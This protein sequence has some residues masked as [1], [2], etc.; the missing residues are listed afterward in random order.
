MTRLPNRYALVASAAA[1]LLLAGPRPALAAD[2]LE[3]RNAVFQELDVKAADG[4]THKERVPAAKVVPGT[5]VIYVI[6]YH[7]VGKQPA[8]DVVITNP[9]PDELAYRPEAGPGPN[10]APEVSV[11]SGKTWGALASLT[12][13]GPDGKPRPAQG[14]DVTHVRWKLAKPIK[15]GEEGSVSYRA[16]LE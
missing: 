16:V 9:I 1:C 2:T 5:E 12:V 15:A 4:T 11:D 6:T 13:K 3:L 14:G 7:N 8:A 10:A